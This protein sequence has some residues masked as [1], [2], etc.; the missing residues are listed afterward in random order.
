MKPSTLKL[1]VVLCL[2]AMLFVH[3]TILWN[4]R[5]KVWKGYSDFAIY[6]C[7]GSMV[8]QGLGH[9]L[10]DTA[11]Q[12]RVQREFAPEVSIR[13]GPLPYNHPPFEALL[14][15]PFTYI[16]YP[17][18]FVLWDL[19]N[20]AM[21]AALPF[22]LRPYLPKLRKYSWPL[23]VLVSLAFSPI[24]F[25]LLQGQDS[26][27]LLFLYALAFVYLKK[28]NLPGAGVWLALGLFKFHLV[29]PFAIL[30][31]VQKKRR[32]IL[33]GFLPAA[34]ALAL[35]SLATVGGE[36]LRAYPHYVMYLE[37]NLPQS[38]IV[39]SDMPNLRG[40]LYLFM[41]SKP[42]FGA[43]L[44]LSSGIVFLFAAWRLR[45]NGN[46]RLL[47]LKFSLAVVVTVL[48]SYH[49]LRHDLSILVLPIFLLADEL[50]DEKR[51]GGWPSAAAVGAIIFFS[52]LQLVLSM[53]Y[54]LLGIFGGVLVLCLFGIARLISL[55]TAEG[56]RVLVET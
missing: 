1:A 15:L 54:N 8:R 45:G 52:P 29:L 5:E 17:Q 40:I 27:L 12:F 28:D 53:R 13:Q 7:A 19:T 16:P 11:T 14:F 3:A 23:W 36:A 31:L 9:Q 30:L 51:L 4:V 50:L 22:L 2:M 34:T 46:L 49:A 37:R 43:A 33:Y 48:V 47:N 39:P 35:I 55:R 20:L 26:I 56:A 41:A 6:Y 32:K 25:A 18:A 44:L 38:A 24:F 42:Y 21:L 10:Y